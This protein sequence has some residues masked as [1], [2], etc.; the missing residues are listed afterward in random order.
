MAE[1]VAQVFSNDIVHL[2][3]IP[4]SM[5]LDQDLM[6]HVATVAKN[7]A[8]HDKL[9]ATSAIA[10]SKLRRS[11]SATTTSA[12]ELDIS[13]WGLGVAPPMA[14]CS[15]IAADSYTGQDKAMILRALSHRR[16]H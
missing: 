9:L 14:P 3:R 4:R 10:S 11:T 16:T 8:D 1:T 13:R 15:S 5:V 2:H 12:I 7:M 6:F